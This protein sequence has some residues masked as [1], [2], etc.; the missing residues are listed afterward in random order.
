MSPAVALNP[1]TPV[2]TLSCILPYVD[3]V[4]VMSVNPGFGGQQFIPYTLDKIRALRRMIDEQ[5]LSCRIE[6]DG[7]VKLSNVRE[8]LDAGADTIVVGSGVFSGDAE[9][10]A[11]EFMDI[12]RNYHKA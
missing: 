1:A 4:L 10:N 3:M 6:I 8:I 9:K 12:F 11:A 7:G 2:E 5:G